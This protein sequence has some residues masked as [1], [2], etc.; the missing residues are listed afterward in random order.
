MG[1]YFVHDMTLNVNQEIRAKDK[2][3][4]YAILP[5]L[6]LFFRNSMYFISPWKECV[7]LLSKIPIFKPTFVLYI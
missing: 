1:N 6:A 5:K 4:I 2:S 7:L 3:H